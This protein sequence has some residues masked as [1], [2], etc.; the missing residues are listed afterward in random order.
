MK[1]TGTGIGLLH[2]KIGN[3]V[4]YVVDG[5][6]YVRRAAIP[7]KKRKAEAEGAHPEHWK[8]MNRFRG[9]QGYYAFFKKCV[10]AEI[11]RAAGE[12]EGRRAD[13][14]F[15]RTNS[16]CFNEE[17]NLADFATFRFSQGALLL[18]RHITLED[19]GAGRWR[20]RWEEERAGA[21]VAGT[22]RLCVGVI[23]EEHPDSPRLLAEVSGV[24]GDLTGTFELEKEPGETVHVYCFW[25]REDGTAFSDSFYFK[26]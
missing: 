23:H 8:L 15:N 2:G 25:G 10:S 13:N 21:L 7:G 9:V 20:V 12:A 14:L 24:R 16:R 4:Y 17:G 5:K 11:W 1:V 18:P 3:L 26:V 19:E 22:D 6:Q